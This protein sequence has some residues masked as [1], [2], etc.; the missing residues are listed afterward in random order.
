MTLVWGLLVVMAIMALDLV[1]RKY[2]QLFLRSH[3]F[4][5]PIVYLVCILLK[6]LPSA[7]FFFLHSNSSNSTHLHSIFSGSAPP[8][9]EPLVLSLRR[10][11]SLAA[12]LGCALCL[13]GTPGLCEEC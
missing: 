3:H 10:N 7:D 6:G 12:R 9:N 13:W 8:R 1:R 2:Y 5:Y 11:D 4:I